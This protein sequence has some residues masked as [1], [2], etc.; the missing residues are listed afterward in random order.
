M[1]TAPIT[2]PPSDPFACAAS[3][4]CSAKSNRSRNAENH[5]ELAADLPTS[6]HN[7]H[8]LAPS[9]L[10]ATTLGRLRVVLARRAQVRPSRPPTAAGHEQNGRQ[11]PNAATKPARPAGR[12]GP[13][14]A[15]AG[16]GPA[17]ARARAPGPALHLARRLRL[18]APAVAATLPAVSGSH[19]H[20]QT[21]GQSRHASLIPL[22]VGPHLRRAPHPARLAS[23]R[24]APVPASPRAS[25]TAGAV[26]LTLLL[27]TCKAQAG[28]EPRHGGTRPGM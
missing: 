9:E 28:L 3:D 22:Y 18:L 1:K 16:Q 4:D 14:R 23:R 10:N 27:A 13:A 15:T 21:A 19:A 2:S 12:S 20:C 6:T 5:G 7:P 11:Q 25:V 17:T 26:S 8:G 24:S